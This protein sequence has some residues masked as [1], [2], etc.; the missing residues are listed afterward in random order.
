MFC[1]NGFFLILWKVIINASDE[2]GGDLTMNEILYLW[3]LP[4][5]AYGVAFFFFG[6][7]R[8]L[9]TYILEGGLDL[10]L[11][12]P[13]NVLINVMLSGMDFGAAGDLIYGGVIGLLAT[14]FDM[15]KFALMIGLSIL[16]AVFYICTEGIIRLFTVL[17]GNTDNIEHVMINTMLVNFSGYPSQIY[18]AGVKFMIYTIVPAAYISFVPI[19]FITT[20]EPK[21]LLIFLAAAVVYVAATVLFAKFVLKRYESGNAIALKS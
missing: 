1:N 5:I 8:K 6:G 10:Y 21:Y 9:G 15:G 12:Q 20:L 17:V 13:K 2:V 19:N 3:S 14:N 11:T 16:A 4:V 7:I 18:G